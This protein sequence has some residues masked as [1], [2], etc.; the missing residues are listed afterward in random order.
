MLDDWPKAF[1]GCNPIS[2][3]MRMAFPERWVR[4]HSLPE[5]KR[6]AENNAEYSILLERHNAVLGAI[7]GKNG[8]SHFAD[9][10]I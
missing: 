10:K 7:R 2:H 5:L 6:Y 9:R 8:R 3:Q 1:P 4:F